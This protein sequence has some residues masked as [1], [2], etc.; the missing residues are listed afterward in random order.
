MDHDPRR[1]IKLGDHIF[2]DEAPLSKAVQKFR[3][4]ELSIQHS[5]DLTVD[6]LGDIDFS[7]RLSYF[8]FISL[9]RDDDE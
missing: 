6:R 2:A 9:P 5:F 7:G 3:S 1:V 8:S 4:M